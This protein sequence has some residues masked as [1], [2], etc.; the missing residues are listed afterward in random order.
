MAT[1]Q[2]LASSIAQFEGFNTLGTIAQR[3]NNPGNLRY[4]SN[5]V[6]AENTVNG[7]FATFANPQDGWDALTNYI[8]S[9]SQL[10]LRDFTYK[11]APPTENN[12]SSYLNFLTQQTGIG[13][14][15]TLGSVL[16]GSN[17]VVSA[18]DSYDIANTVSDLSAGLSL[19]D[20]TTVAM[21][22]GIVIVGLAVSDVF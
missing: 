12:T 20:P 13:A 21:L 10:T 18:S 9:N 11:Y 14:D 19:S 2:Q 4:A 3:N 17:N 1:V 5:Q 15:Q 7:Q 6:G 8:D 22:A 16:D